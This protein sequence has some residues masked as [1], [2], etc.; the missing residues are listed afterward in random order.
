MEESKEI[1]VYR[2]VSDTHFERFVYQVEQSYETSP[3]DV[4]V[5]LSDDSEATI[6]LITC[7][8]I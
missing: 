7:T 6:T 2:K 3:Y 8:P 1:W 4:D 5:L